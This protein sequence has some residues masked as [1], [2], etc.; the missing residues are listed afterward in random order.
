MIGLI[1]GKSGDSLTDELHNVGHQ[2]A[3]VC[4][5]DN[6]PGSDLADEVCISDLRNV[7]EIISFFKEHDV[8]KVII[9]TGHRFA[10]D[11][12]EELEHNDIHTNIE[13]EK[14]KLAKNKWLFKK[15]LDK[16]S[17]LTPQAELF[18]KGEVDSRIN[19]LALY[20]CV[21]KSTN[22]SFQPEKVNSKE[23][24]IELIE[25]E[26]HTFQNSDLMLE[27]YIN[28]YDCTVA[29]SSDGS[30]V[31]DYGITYYS[32]AKEYGL[33][34]FEE[35]DTCKFDKATEYEICKIAREVVEKCGF[36]GLV[37]LDFIIKEK[38]IYVLELNTVMVTGYH[39]SAYPF[40][41]ANG[42]NIAKEA[43]NVTLKIL[44]A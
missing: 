14:S 13:I 32:K 15:E 22:D 7:N 37:R 5:Y 28:G 19:N 27:Q 40:F 2:V 35:A 36:K 41:K 26:R 20:P 1:A 21:A 18:E 3:I 30:I 44:G 34:G 39:G 17:I 24:L 9:G 23:E 42:I 8:K 11:L 33:K 16:I 25:R 10:F 4:G 6:E 29:V 31:K 12:V 43:V 38:D